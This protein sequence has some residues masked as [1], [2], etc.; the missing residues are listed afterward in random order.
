VHFLYLIKITREVNSKPDKEGRK[1]ERDEELNKGN[2]EESMK[3][4][5]K[6]RTFCTDAQ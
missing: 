3:G 6:E 4:R 1:K 5:K 2:D